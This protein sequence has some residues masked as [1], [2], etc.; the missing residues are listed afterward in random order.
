MLCE[1]LPFVRAKLPPLTSA[2]RSC[3]SLTALF[4]IWGKRKYPCLKGFVL[5]LDLVSGTVASDTRQEVLELSCQPW[6]QKLESSGA[7]CM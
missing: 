2:C 4:S 3:H 5:A 7:P 6:A 1:A